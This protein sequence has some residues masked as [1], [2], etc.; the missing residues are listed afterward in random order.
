MEVTI[1]DGV[2]EFPTLGRILHLDSTSIN[3]TKIGELSLHAFG[4]DL[5]N[6]RKYGL[7]MRVDGITVLKVTFQ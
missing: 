5:Q 6:L 3:R 4:L 1:S 7:V 2:R